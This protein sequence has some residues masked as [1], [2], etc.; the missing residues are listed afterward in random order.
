MKK[1]AAPNIT[2]NSYTAILSQWMHKHFP[3]QSFRLVSAVKLAY[4]TNKEMLTPSAQPIFV[5]YFLNV[6][7][8]I[9]SIAW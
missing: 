8:A 9:F 2:R 7:N 6:W 3:I 4:I 1:I 5:L